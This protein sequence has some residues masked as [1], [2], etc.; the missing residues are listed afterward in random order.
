MTLDQF[1]SAIGNDQNLDFEDSMQVISDNYDFIATG[2]QNG[3]LYNEAGQ[4]E[5][6][7]KILAFAQI[8]NLS[9]QQ[10]LACFGRFYQDVLSTPE[11]TDH[12]NIRNFIAN[13]WQGVKFDQ[14]ALTAK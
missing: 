9:E 3:E 2:F 7:C 13:G 14:V 11:G 8:H 10:T 1:I 4:N 12:G 5:G 6:S